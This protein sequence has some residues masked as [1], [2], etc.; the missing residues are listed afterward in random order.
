MY[1]PDYFRNEDPEAIDKIV[2][3]N[4][5]ATLITP[6]PDGLKATHLPLLFARLDD[7]GTITGH[8][9]RAN[10]HWKA[11]DGSAESLA[12]FQGSDAYISP[13][14]YETAPAVP[15]WNFAVVHMR[16]TIELID[17]REWLSAHVEEM[18]EFHESRTLD[19]AHEPSDPELKAAILG[20]IVGFMMKVTSIEAKFKLNQNR[21]DADRLAV[22]DALD[23]LGNQTASDVAALMREHGE[24]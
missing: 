13:E 15:T 24:G 18:V 22:V 6:S 8:M 9:A 20:G 21:S 12:I 5:L 17:D 7:A 10:D 3:E 14:W 16:G 1:I 23:A 19:H 2:S 11:L 4:G